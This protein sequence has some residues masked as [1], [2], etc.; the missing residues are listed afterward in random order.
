MSS[1]SVFAGWRRR[2]RPVL[3]HLALAL[4]F[5]P[6][7]SAQEPSAERLQR[8]DREPQNW[9]T[10]YGNYQGWRYS[11]L[12]QINRENVRQLVPV[13]AF[14][15]GRP[16]GG[17][18]AT[19]LVVDGVL[20]LAG[21]FNRVFALDA[22]TGR[23]LWKYFYK[24]PETTIP[25]TPGTRGIAVG[26]GLVFLGTLDNHVVALDAKTGR[27]VWDVEVEDVRQ[28]GCNITSAPLVVKDKVIVGGTGG[29]TAH[30]GYLNAFDA[31]TGKHIWRFYTIPGPGEPGF[32]TWD[33]DS[34]KYGGAP[35]WLTGSYDPQLNTLYWGVGNPSSDFY[36][37]LRKGDNLYTNSI[38]ALDPDTGRLKWYFQEIPHDLY[39]FDSAYECVL[40]DVERDGRRQSLLVHPNKGGYTWVID[41]VT[42][43]YI[44][45]WPHIETINWL[46]GVDAKGQPHG[47]LPVPLDTETFV[48]PNAAGGRSWNHS[49]YS[50][51]T[52]WWYNTGTEWCGTI[53]PRRQEVEEGRELFGGDIGFSPPRDKPA[54][55]HI[56]AYDP[57][58]GAKRWSH[59]MKYVNLSSLLAT[60]GDLIFAGDVEGQAFALDART[61][62]RLWS[63][64]TGGGI[65]GSAISYSVNGRQYIAIPTGM[66]SLIRG[67]V[68]VVWPESAPHLPQPT[69]TLLVFALPENK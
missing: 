6:T 28:C 12:A 2:V 13:F 57:L 46:K 45:A 38:I 54:Y 9:L 20:Y 7:A 43:K 58:S 51:R 29:E 3:A 27:E 1:R 22:A 48:C 26:H 37:E 56:D 50:P 65:S 21:P 59:R 39:D 31:R 32:E 44:G 4:A 18:N 24:L 61:G 23:Q 17:L 62:E 68:P 36:G 11:A 16:E 55:G 10:Y 69:S 64:N 15:T 41:R 67:A 19:P 5:A 35:T 53:R 25:Y 47:L 52:G 33:R 40:V 8:S 30:R 66:G 60:G 42:G 34:W 63:F 49:A 14:H